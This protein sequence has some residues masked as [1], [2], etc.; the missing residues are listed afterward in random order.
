MLLSE[1][2]LIETTN[3]ETEFKQSGSPKGQGSVDF[4]FGSLN[5]EAGKVLSSDET[6]S[7]VIVLA[8]PK[9]IGYRDD[10]VTEEFSLRMKMRMT[11]TYPSSY[12]LDA[13]F[14]E[15]NSWFF[16]S[17]LKTYF[18]FYAEEILKQSGIDGIKLPLN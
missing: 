16:S 8:E 4:V 3:L 5:L 2:K 10:G 18:K 17:F 6:K 13:K 7:V 15:G 9:A 11:Y 1:F 12:T 14:L